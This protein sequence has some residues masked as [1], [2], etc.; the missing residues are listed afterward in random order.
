M[1]CS[2]KFK[3]KRC[4]YLK[5]V[6]LDFVLLVLKLCPIQVVI[7]L[8]LWIKLTMGQLLLF[9]LCNFSSFFSYAKDILVINHFSLL[10]IDRYILA[11]QHIIT[12]EERSSDTLWS[13][14]WSSEL[15]QNRLH[16]SHNNSSL[17]VIFTKQFLTK[18]PFFAVLTD[19]LYSHLRYLKFKGKYQQYGPYFQN[20]FPFLMTMV[21]RT[22]LIVDVKVYVETNLLVKKRV[23][24]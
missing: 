15:P 11:I 14:S 9:F 12:H 24:K 18:A 6:A 20:I 4:C 19:S 21:L 10:L 8:P 22:C 2:L 3:Q 7:S 17:K 23:T 1:T 16:H 13:V 5:N